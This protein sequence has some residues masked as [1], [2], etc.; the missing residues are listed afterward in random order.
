M[1]FICCDRED[2]SLMENQ[3]LRRKDSKTMKLVIVA[4]KRGL[5]RRRRSNWVGLRRHILERLITRMY[6]PSIPYITII[7]NFCFLSKCQVPSDSILN[8]QQKTSAT[9]PRISNH[10]SQESQHKLRLRGKQVKK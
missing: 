2:N 3:C 7:D 5:E 9:F 4:T 8:I 6:Y 10:I 1:V